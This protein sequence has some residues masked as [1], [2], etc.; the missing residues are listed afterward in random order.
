MNFDDYFAKMMPAA[1]QWFAEQA[2]ETATGQ[3]AVEPARDGF[4][5]PPGMLEGLHDALKLT[6]YIEVSDEL[7]THVRRPLPPLPWRWRLRNR[8][9]SWREQTARRAYRAIAGDW[10]DDG[11][12]DW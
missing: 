1:E 5:V 6:A 3:P 4:L 12:D 2:A 11:E 8:V 7:F 10:P 9:T